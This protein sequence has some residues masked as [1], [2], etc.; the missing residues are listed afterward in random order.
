[1]CAAIA[2]DVGMVLA[3]QVGNA[4]SA[5]DAIANGEFGPRPWSNA[6]ASAAAPARPAA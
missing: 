6:A 2:R 3:A 4:Q 5:R 1:V